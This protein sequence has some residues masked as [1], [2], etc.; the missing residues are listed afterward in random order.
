MN[1]M[2][3]QL[4]INME[5]MNLTMAV[6]M[7]ASGIGASI[8]L[9]IAD[10]IGRRPVYLFAMSVYL[11]ANLSLGLQRNYIAMLILRMLQSVGSSGMTSES[12]FTSLTDMK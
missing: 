8:F 9:G 4:H 11:C 1:Q 2:A 6:Y 5:L 3:K 12:S 7:F 10:S